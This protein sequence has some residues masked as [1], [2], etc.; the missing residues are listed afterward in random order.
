MPAVERPPLPTPLDARLRIFAA[1]ALFSTGGAAIKATALSGWQVA[2]LRSGVAALTVFV[3]LPE[4]RRRLRLPVLA[5]A[6]AYAA[7]MILFVL[8]N[9]LTTAA[10]TI[11]LQSTAPLYLLLLGPLVLGEAVKRRDLVYM[12]ALA[13]G[14]GAFFVGVDEP[15][16]TAPEPFAGNL[17]A[18]G[19]GVTW[20]LTVIGLRALGREDAASVVSGQGGRGGGAQAVFLGNLLAFLFCL[21]WALPFTGAGALDWAIVGYLGVFQIGVAYILLTAAMRQV[22]ALEAALLLLVEPVL[23]PVWAW[24][25]HGERPGPW[26]L[27]GGAVIL[28]ATGIKTAVDFRRARR[29]QRAPPAEPPRWPPSGDRPP[30][31]G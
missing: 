1:A 20:A 17:A 28:A 26:S 13:V 12:A 14:L 16:A 30:A 5:V 11:Y 24:L 21:P 10:N 18:T 25:V 22:P 6:A 3:V 31:P 9:K 27:A 15:S 19:S 29:A 8:A 2:S 4:A 7:T 23:N